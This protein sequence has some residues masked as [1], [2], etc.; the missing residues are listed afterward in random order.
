MKSWNI[1]STNVPLLCLNLYKKH[2]S[3]LQLKVNTLKALN[4]IIE[5]V[6]PDVIMFYKFVHLWHL[7]LQNV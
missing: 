6:F 1:E 4:N 2:C 3:I 5:F 7:C